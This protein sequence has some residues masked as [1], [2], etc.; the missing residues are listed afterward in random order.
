MQASA[1]TTPK[2]PGA[3][4]A[5]TG[6]GRW[7]ALA[8]A[9][10]SLPMHTVYRPSTL[11]GEAMP[12]VIWGN[13]ACRD[14]GLQHAMFLREVASHG[15]LV[16]ALGRPRQERGVESGDTAPQQAPPQAPRRMPD[17]THLSQMVDAIDW[18][19]AENK[20]SGGS[21]EGRIDPSRIGVMGH[22]CGGLQAIAMSADPRISTSIIFNSGVYVRPGPENRSG[23]QIGKDALDRLHAPIAY[24]DGGPT[25]I[26]H[27][28]AVDDVSRIARV[29]VFFGALPVGHGGT[30]WKD[31]NG[32]AWARVAV[33]WLNWRL[34]GDAASGRWFAGEDCGLCSAEGWSVV[35]K[36]MD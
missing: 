25:D 7:P 28:N 18:A 2:G 5:A 20:R 32:G 3:V 9:V 15:Y 26:A 17:E 19:V 8:E 10:A 12:L 6:T 36:N 31:A 21:L 22:S 1:T 13:G 14:N 11:P 30:F 4:S 23:I 16:I 35:R 34:K 24:F 27:A 33:A 29:P